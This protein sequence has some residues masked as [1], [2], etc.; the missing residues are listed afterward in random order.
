M[1][2]ILAQADLPAHL[3]PRKPRL[4]AAYQSSD[5]YPARATLT[6]R[7]C[8]RRRDISGVPDARQ[9]DAVNASRPSALKSAP[10][11]RPDA[12]SSLLSEIRL[13][14]WRGASAAIMETI[15]DRHQPGRFAVPYEPTDWG[16]IGTVP[17]GVTRP[18]FGVAGIGGPHSAV[19]DEAPESIA[20]HEGLI[21]AET[22]IRDLAPTP[23]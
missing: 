3:K 5:D 11:N 18:G 16:Q 15:V 23:G 9:T 1:P 2:Q 21:R 17:L 4:K 20:R 12:A 6:G 7:S 13:A 14:G 19:S 10:M 22:P 8:R